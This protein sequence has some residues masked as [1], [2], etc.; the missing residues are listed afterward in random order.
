MKSIWYSNLTV[1]LVFNIY[2]EHFLPNNDVKVHKTYLAI[3]NG[4]LEKNSGQWSEELIRYE[5]GKK[6]IEKAQTTFRVLDKNSNSSLVEMKEKLQQYHENELLHQKENQRSILSGEEKERSRLA[7]ELH[8]GLGPILT[9]LRL[10]IQST[11]INQ[12]LKQQLLKKLV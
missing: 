9:T 8:D 4:E 11:S 1:I 12:K 2:F 3:C 7:Q 5:N 10:D 6:I